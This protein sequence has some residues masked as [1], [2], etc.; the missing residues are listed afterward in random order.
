MTEKF[1]PTLRRTVDLEFLEAQ[2]GSNW[3]QKL[4][5]DANEIGTM[6]KEK[7]DALNKRVEAGLCTLTD[8]D[9]SQLYGLSCP[10]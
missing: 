8:E 1:L 2:F 5:D 6:P 3:A 10:Q 4:V 9:V 7:W